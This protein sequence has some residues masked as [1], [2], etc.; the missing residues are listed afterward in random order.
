ME[1]EFWRERWREGRIGFHQDQVTPMLTQYWPTLGLRSD[2]RVFVPLAGKS[3]DL[4]WLAAQGH[5]VL[6]IEL[7][8][9]AVTQFFAEHALA[10]QRHVTRYGTHHVAADLHGGRIE[11]ICGDVFDLDAELLLT[12]HAI[13][14]RAA[15][16]ALPPPLRQRYV[17]QVY[18]QLPAGCRGLL[19]TMEYP[20]DDMDGPPFSVPQ[21]EVHERLGL[22]WSVTTLARRD[23]LRQQPRFA[24]AGVRSLHTAAYDL[25]RSAPGPAAGCAG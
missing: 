1:P 10:P 24:E 9:L 11:L 17:A 21:T 5:H 8:P 13:F 6:G 7:S 4:V 16:I 3:H 12:C 15:L 25:E 14:D 23:I 19:I 20:Q 2:A 18:G 22:H